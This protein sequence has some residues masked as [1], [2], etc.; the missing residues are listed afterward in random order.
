MDVDAVAVGAQ[1]FRCLEYMKTL[2]WE[3]LP[4]FDPACAGVL[5]PIDFVGAGVLASTAHL[6]PFDAFLSWLPPPPPAKQRPEGPLSGGAAASAADP[7]AAS[8]GSAALKRVLK[9]QR[10]REAGEK[11][12]DTSGATLPL[13]MDSDEEESVVAKVVAAMEEVR[14][15][16]GE[17]LQGDYKHFKVRL[18]GGGRALD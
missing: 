8:S 5:K 18:L 14:A 4:E 10:G 15:E 12:P 17:V 16:V 6:I 9:R 13:V 1:F 3:D 11:F 7:T 2:S